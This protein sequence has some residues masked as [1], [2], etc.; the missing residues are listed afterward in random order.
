MNG[1]K[2]IATQLRRNHLTQTA[3]KGEILGLIAADYYLA[4]GRLFKSIGKQFSA[5]KHPNAASLPTVVMPHR[6]L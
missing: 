3:A 6:W 4:I 5:L 2:A 1:Y